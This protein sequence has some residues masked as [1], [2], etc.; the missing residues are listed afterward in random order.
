MRGWRKKKEKKIINYLKML[1]TKAKHKRIMHVHCALKDSMNRYAS[2][3]VYVFAL[4]INIE[5]ID[6]LPLPHFYVCCWFLSSCVRTVQMVRYGIVSYRIVSYRK[7][8]KENMALQL[9]VPYML[10]DHDLCTCACGLTIRDEPVNSYHYIYISHAIAFVCCLAQY[11]IA[12][13]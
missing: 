4:H 6:F 5:W 2:V 13:H 7:V 8:S 10:P 1:E 12:Q 11:R 3:V 9:S